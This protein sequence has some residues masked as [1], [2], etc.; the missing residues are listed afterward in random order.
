ME[1]DKRNMRQLNNYLSEKSDREVTFIEFDGV[2]LHFGVQE[3]WTLKT[4]HLDKSV[5]E[6]K[7][8]KHGGCPKWFNMACYPCQI[9]NGDAVFLI[10]NNMSQDV[11]ERFAQNK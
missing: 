2:R 11:H 8:I 7:R 4:I 9:M 1:I 10:E 6:A 3:N 5:T